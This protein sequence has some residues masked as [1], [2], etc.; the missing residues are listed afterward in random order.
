M[1]V[2]STIGSG[3]GTSISAA[4]PSGA[5]ANAIVILLA[6]TDL[7]T[8]VITWPAGFLEL[9]QRSWTLDGQT[10]GAAW[11]RCGGTDTGNYTCGF[12]G[13]PF[14]RVVIAATFSGR[15]VSAPPTYSDPTL[16]TTGN[17]SPVTI[18]APTITAL[19][20]DDLLWVSAPDVNTSGAGTGHTAPSG[21]T[22]AEDGELAF[23]NFSIAYKENVAAG[24]T[25]GVAGTFTMSGGTSGWAATLI[26][27]PKEPAVTVEYRSLFTT[28]PRFRLRTP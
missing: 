9:F 2:D 6:S 10:F 24:A 25:G 19:E 12:S 11:K 26:R 23:T 27:M 8:D 13:T 18:T 4:V 3:T 28:F 14:D 15:S 16:N 20:G 22:E 17:T 1:Y 21:Y 7:N 5:V